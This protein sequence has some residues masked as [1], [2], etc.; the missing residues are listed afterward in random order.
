MNNGTNWTCN[1]PKLTLEQKLFFDQYTWRLETFGNLVFGSVGILLNLVTIVVF[2]ATTMRNNFFNR[3]LICLAVFD[4]LY[5]SCE[6]S[7]VFRHRHATLLHQQVF[8][9]F[10]YPA[11]NMFMVCSIYMIVI[12]AFERY[13]AITYPVAYRQ[14]SIANMTHRIIC[15]ILPGIVFSFIYY[16]PKFFD[17][18][19]GQ[20]KFR[21]KKITDISDAKHHQN[22]ETLTEY[23]LIPTK[24]RLHQ[25]YIF[26]YINVSN[27]ILTAFVPVCLLMF[28]NYKIISGIRKLKARQPSA[29]L[30][31][32]VESTPRKDNDIKKTFILFSIVILFILCHSLRITLN[33]SEFI[34]GARIRTLN[35]NGY[36]EEM[37]RGCSE[38]D[39]WERYL[40]P[41]NN[42]CVILNSSSNFFIY[43]FFDVSFQRVLS[44]HFNSI[45]KR[46]RGIRRVSLR[47][48][49]R[50]DCDIE[51]SNMI[52]TQV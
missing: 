15:Y 43:V 6:I 11:R 25:Q 22:N 41:F 1:F 45:W 24:L 37:K 10:V 17:L 20:I 16:I 18:K 26:W 8:V 49:V 2:S 21:V 42:L 38:L 19:V 44:E 52:G 47:R 31:N 23:V 39:I 13:L 29:R 51:L 9:R 46:I 30:P 28:L 48:A 12:L 14:R 34:H 4:T 36:D 7:E 27:F 35:F 3:L 50:A 32:G 5:L 40:E 33:I